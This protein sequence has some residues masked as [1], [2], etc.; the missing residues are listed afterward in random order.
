MD[1]LEPTIALATENEL[2][3]GKVKRVIEVTER[4]C[5]LKEL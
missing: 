1:T 2:Y 3:K 5:D 4:D